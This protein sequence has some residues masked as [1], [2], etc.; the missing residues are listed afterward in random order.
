MIGLQELLDRMKPAIRG[1]STGGYRARFSTSDV[2]Q[3]CA[4]Q[5]ISEFSSAD[6]DASPRDRQITLA[7]LK[8]IAR[9]TA[10][11]MRR[12]NS[13]ACRSIE[14]E[15]NVNLGFKSKEALRPDEEIEIRE[16]TSKLVSV[17]ATIGT[18]QRRVIDGHYRNGK[19][20]RAIAL[21]MD[22]CPKK[23]QRVHNAALAEIKRKLRS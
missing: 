14:R 8:T 15:E 18:F 13:A 23:I 10:A 9:G 21:E 4:I 17:L 6:A 20:L 1:R 3:E 5:L 16:M 7:W 11:K 12:K 22:I 19:S 2:T